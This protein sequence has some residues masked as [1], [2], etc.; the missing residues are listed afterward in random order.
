[1]RLLL[2]EAAPVW[3]GAANGFEHSPGRT[4]AAGRSLGVARSGCQLHDERWNA[5]FSSHF[6]TPGSTPSTSCGSRRR[7]AKLETKRAGTADNRDAEVV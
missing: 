7:P 5:F 4:S 1:V 2:W 6:D 3:R